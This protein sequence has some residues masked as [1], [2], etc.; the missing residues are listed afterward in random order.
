MIKCSSVIYFQE[1]WCFWIIFVMFYVLIN[2]LEFIVIEI[3]KLQSYG[4]ATI[5]II[6]EWTNTFCKLPSKLFEENIHIQT[7]LS[8]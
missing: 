2:F 6:Y 5:N 7:S 4:I 8:I 1:F 3:L